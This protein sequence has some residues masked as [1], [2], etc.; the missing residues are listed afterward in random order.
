MHVEVRLCWLILG[1]YRSRIRSLDL[2]LLEILSFQEAK[3]PGNVRE[4]LNA[5]EMHFG[6]FSSRL[7]NPKGYFAS[8]G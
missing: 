1:R 8:R 2:D 4:N 3:E 5:L 6:F 7:N